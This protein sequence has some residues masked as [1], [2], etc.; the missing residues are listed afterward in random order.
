MEGPVL[1]QSEFL[2][3]VVN[4]LDEQTRKR[5][6]DIVDKKDEEKRT[7]LEKIKALNRAL[8]KK[9]M[10]ARVG[11]VWRT[12]GPVLSIVLFGVGL[13]TYDKN[14]TMGVMVAIV[15]GLC[16]IA[17]ILGYT[18]TPAP[19]ILDKP[20]PSNAKGKEDKKTE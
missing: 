1:T 17:T 6:R 20:L 16:L 13:F 2:D 7:N 9:Q 15:G 10:E 8:E 12:F 19:V 14:E 18:N 5:L 3:C 11:S 4:A